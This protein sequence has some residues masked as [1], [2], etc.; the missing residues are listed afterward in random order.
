MSTD[1]RHRAA[2]QQ[3]P[4]LYPERRMTVETGDRRPETGE[5]EQ[6]TRKPGKGRAWTPVPRP[7]ACKPP[8]GPVSGF[9]SPVSGLELFAGIPYRAIRG[10][11]GDRVYKTY[12]DKVIVTRVPCF[13]GY[14]PTAAQRERRK[15]LRAATAYAQAVYADPA[16]KAIYVT[17]AKQLGRQPFRLAVSD[18]L[19]GRPR[20]KLDLASKP[21]LRESAAPADASKGNSRAAPRSI[22]GL[23][24]HCRV[25]RH[26]R[27][28]CAVRIPGIIATVRRPQRGAPHLSRVACHSSHR[29]RPPPWPIERAKLRF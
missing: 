8:A 24:R 29:R 18:F 15:K 12:G 14:V 7:V 17:A 21:L 13:D 9:R 20:V 19:R 10:R 28:T 22:R 3:Q 27:L 2:S 4:S 16:A 6:E 25:V 1:H 11:L 23:S 26:P 5:R